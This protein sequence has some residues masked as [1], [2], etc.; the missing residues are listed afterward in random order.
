MLRMKE[1]RDWETDAIAAL[2]SW[3]YAI[4]NPRAVHAARI[5][6]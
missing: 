5:A 4:T 3:R 2:P 6:V 1:N